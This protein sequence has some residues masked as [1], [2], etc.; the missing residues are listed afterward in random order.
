MPGSVRELFVF[1]PSTL[2]E[3]TA[4]TTSSEPDADRE[5]ACGARRSA[6]C[7]RA[8]GPRAPPPSRLLRSE[9][10]PPSAGCSIGVEPW[11]RRATRCRPCNARRG[12][13]LQPLLPDLRAAAIADAI[14][15]V[16]EFLERPPHILELRRQRVGLANA[17]DASDRLAGALPTLLPKPIVAAG[18]R[19]TRVRASRA[20]PRGMPARP[21]APFGS[22]RGRGS[23]APPSASWI[24][25]GSRTSRSCGSATSIVPVDPSATNRVKPASCS[26]TASPGDV[27]VGEFEANAGAVGHESD[28]CVGVETPS[29]ALRRAQQF[30]RPRAAGDHRSMVPARRPYAVRRHRSGR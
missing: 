29:G 23:R 28:A 10:P 25:R 14:G 2:T 16:V 8:A 9:A 30:H 11:G 18:S 13:G 1:A 7:D 17:F 26:T 5:S 12:P 3:P 4:T 20:R 27:L 21:R 19:V 24:L 15:S 22:R 6:R